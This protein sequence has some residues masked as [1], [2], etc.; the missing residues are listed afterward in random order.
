MHLVSP[1]EASASLERLKRGETAARG[2][3]FDQHVHLVERL[4]IHG[5]GPR[6][7]VR[8]V[9]HDVF[10]AAYGSVRSFRGDAAQLGGW[11]RGV[12]VRVVRKHLRRERVRKL[13]GLWTE[14]A[15]EDELPSP[16]ASPELRAAAWR[17]HR[18]TAQLPVDDRL[19]V[20]LRYLE[21]LELTEVAEATQSS[22]ATV[23]RRLRRARA[24]LLEWSSHDVLL[25]SW[26]EGLA[27]EA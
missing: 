3:F 27:D 24:R 4:V 19:A 11:L 8:D 13:V 22:L 15:Q 2:A 14:P 6:P 1:P 12:A 10:I 9:V 20:S 5:M 16:E 21:G 26:A 7:D 23:K 18:L 25:C 17:L